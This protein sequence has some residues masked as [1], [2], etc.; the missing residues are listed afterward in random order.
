M[1]KNQKTVTTAAIHFVT[2]HA[3]HELYFAQ[4]LQGSHRNHTCPPCTQIGTTAS[5]GLH[6]DQPVAVSSHVS[7]AMSH[8]H[9][10]HLLHASVSRSQRRSIATD[11]FPITL[12][13]CR[14][15]CHVLTPCSRLPSSTDVIS[16]TDLSRRARP[17]STVFI[18][19]SFSFTLQMC[20]V[21]TDIMSQEK[22][23][24]FCQTRA[25]VG[26]MSATGGMERGLFQLSLDGIVVVHLNCRVCGEPT[27]A[28]SHCRL[29]RENSA[30]WPPAY[31]R[32]FQKVRVVTAA[33]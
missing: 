24:K 18:T 15:L 22:T 23:V 7:L 16:C 9:D 21:T 28:P 20:Q 10:L 17:S 27:V 29:L 2:E 12:S 4:L 31:L 6:T 5:A 3:V 30:A 32:R 25:N 8:H 33:Q 19:H 14:T 26:V 1:K 11:N 13:N